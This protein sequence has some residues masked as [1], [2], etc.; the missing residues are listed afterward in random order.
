ML[1]SLPEEIQQRVFA[2][3]RVR[4]RLRVAATCKDMRQ[5]VGIHGACLPSLY[6]AKTPETYKML[7]SLDD[8]YVERFA[9]MIRRLSRLERKLRRA[10]VSF[11]KYLKQID[12]LMV[13]DTE[14]MAIPAY[15]DVMLQQSPVFGKDEEQK[16][17]N[18]M[19]CTAAIDK[20]R[21]S[22][23]LVLHTDQRRLVLRWDMA[24]LGWD[25]SLWLKH[26]GTGTTVSTK[27]SGFRLHHLFHGRPC[28][29]ALGV[30]GL[31]MG[32][33]DGAT[34]E[35]LVV[36]DEASAPESIVC[37]PMEVWAIQRILAIMSRRTPRSHLV[38][39]TLLVVGPSNGYLRHMF[40]LIPRVHLLEKQ[41]LLH[42][43][44]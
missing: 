7:N 21:A 2:D 30:R 42:V 19:P 31:T 36:L 16:P 9:L 40:R 43:I 34:K 28:T 39:P 13:L 37:A 10:R 24:L 33:L 11:G 1:L 27:V 25:V 14:R 41:P 15:G 17:L 5:N 20:T 26:T 23:I 3:L 18:E 35:S 8:V 38:L 12:Q 29:M 6:E 4:D 22:I 44:G 32:N